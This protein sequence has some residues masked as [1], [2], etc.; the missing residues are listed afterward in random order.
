MRHV[1]GEFIGVAF[2]DAPNRIFILVTKRAASSDDLN[3][4]WLSRMTGEKVNSL[5]QREAVI[6]TSYRVG[7]KTKKKA[8]TT[9]PS[10][11]S[12]RGLTDTRTL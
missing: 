5:K 1:F 11:V 6:M 9:L 10:S 8:I 2:V 4:G 12:C 3:Q 7:I